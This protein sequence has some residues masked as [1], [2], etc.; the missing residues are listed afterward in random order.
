MH[1]G[2]THNN[3]AI[4]NTARVGDSSSSKITQSIAIGSGNRVDP[5][6]R[7]EGAWAKGDQS[8]AVGGNV[9]ANGN[10]SV[11]IGGDDLDSV[12]G[13]RYSGNATDKFIKYNEKGAKDR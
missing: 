2:L 8:I 9:L 6:G 11:A 3:I 12:G 7:P 13:T 4:G 5:Q 1:P 10:S